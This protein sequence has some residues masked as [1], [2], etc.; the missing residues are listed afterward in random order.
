MIT[1]FIK[2]HTYETRMVKGGQIIFVKPCEY[3]YKAVSDEYI[4]EHYQEWCTS[5]NLRPESD[6]TAMDS[7]RKA[8]TK[9][10]F[11]GRTH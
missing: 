7:M 5:G 6:Y 8:I 2:R 4:Y 9:E 11:R 1:E 3:G 10:Y